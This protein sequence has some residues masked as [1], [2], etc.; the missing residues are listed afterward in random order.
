MKMAVDASDRS[1]CNR[2]RVGCVLVCNRRVIATGYNGSNH[3]MPHCDD[4][5]HLIVDEHCVRTVHAEVNAVIQSALYGVS[6]KGA[7][8]YV[9]HIPCFNCT[10]VLYNAG[11]ERVVYTVGYG[12]MVDFTIDYFAGTGMK[13]ESFIE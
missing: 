8:A 1:T 13:I 4:I 7:T 10:K 11:V 3:G 5:G 2:A 12:S 9:T 6:T